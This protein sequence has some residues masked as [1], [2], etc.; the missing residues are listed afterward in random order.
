MDSSL[1]YTLGWNFHLLNN[2]ISSDEFFK[3]FYRLP[4]SFLFFWHPIHLEFMPKIRIWVFP[5]I[6][7]HYFVKLSTFSINLSSVK[8]HCQLSNAISLQNTKY[9][10][11]SRSISFPFRT[12]LMSQHQEHFDDSVREANCTILVKVYSCVCPWWILHIKS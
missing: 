3:C 10:E 11:C 8:F 6:V 2:K 12:A 9:S 7:L 5:Q 1:S 4:F